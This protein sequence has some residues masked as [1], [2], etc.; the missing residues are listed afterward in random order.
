MAAAVAEGV[1][2]NHISRE[3]SDIR[4]LANFYKEIFGFEEIESPNLEFKVIWLKG[5]G[6]FAFHLIERNP[7]YNL[8]E[9]PWSAT[10]PV[11][12][13]SHLPRGHHVCFSVSNFHSF[14]QALKDK[15]I[16]T[17]EKS[18]PDGKIKQVFFF[19]PDGREESLSLLSSQFL[20]HT[21]LCRQWIGGCR[22]MNSTLTQKA[23]QNGQVDSHE[24]DDL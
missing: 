14:V 24:A 9:G 18:L 1:S 21:S 15:G 23:A 10:S 2:L 13:P 20:N 6:A 7:D 17:F 22:S 11:A 3:S 4:R 12:D 19:D 5:P 8:P 16:Q